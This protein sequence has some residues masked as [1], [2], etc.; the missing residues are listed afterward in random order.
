MPKFEVRKFARV[1]ESRLVGRVLETL[2]I[3]P[4]GKP[5][6]LLREEI[7]RKMSSETKQATLKEVLGTDDGSAVAKVLDIIFSAAYPNYISRQV[8]RVVAASK[9]PIKIPSTAKNIA[10]RLGQYG[11][12]PIGE[13]IPTFN[14]INID[15]WGVRPAISKSMIED[16]EYDVMQM[17]LE[18]AAKAM[19][20]AENKQVITTI[21][22]ISSA[23]ARTRGTSQ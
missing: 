6:N 19:A 23:Q 13:E 1:Q 3:D 12:I 2:K 7:L 20:E 22:A 9:S 5:C 17:E 8:L 16:E 21:Q 15:L 14:Q 10:S 4:L 11:E 18:G